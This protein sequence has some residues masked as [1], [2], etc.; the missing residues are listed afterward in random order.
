MP[1][2]IYCRKRSLA[3]FLF[4]L[5]SAF[6]AGRRPF[7]MFG[8]FF[9]LYLRRFQLGDHRPFNAPVLDLVHANVQ[10]VGVYLG[11]GTVVRHHAQ[12]AKDHA[13]QGIEL[14]FG[15]VFHAQGLAHGLKV[16]AAAHPPH[17]V[18]QVL[19]VALHGSYSS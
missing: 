9:V 7:L 11:V 5:F 12:R 3:F 1:G 17:A 4:L 8:V 14:L 10:A 2:D 18:A 6:A 13:A 19:N 15:Q 16:Q